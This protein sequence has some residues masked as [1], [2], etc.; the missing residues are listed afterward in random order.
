MKEKK[1][2]QEL[3][4]IINEQVQSTVAK[5]QKKETTKKATTKK[6]SKKATKEEKVTK[7]V[8]KVQNLE[9]VEEVISKREVKYKYPDNIIN[10]HLA[11]KRWR[12]EVRNTL[13]ALE[14]ELF[15]IKDT[16]SKEYKEA[17]KK[18]QDKQKAVYKEGHLKTLTA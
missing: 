17:L 8:A 10:D 1:E 12:Q 15:R 7:E 4:N 16:T 3:A 11:K 13:R 5:L 6:E 2:K 14:R 18:Y 9:I